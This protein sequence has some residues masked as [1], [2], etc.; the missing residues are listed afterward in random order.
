MGMDRKLANKVKAG[1]QKP[2][3][4]FVGETDGGDHWLIPAEK[5]EKWFK[6]LEN[7]ED[8][9]PKWAQYLQFHLDSLTFEN[10][11]EE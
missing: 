7:Q 6:Y 9:L 2:Q 11:K 8:E 3:R 5:R 4:Y 1:V 10:P